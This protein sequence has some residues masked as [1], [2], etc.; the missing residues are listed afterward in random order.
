MTADHHRSGYIVGASL[1]ETSVK[2]GYVVPLLIVSIASHALA[3]A[4][5]K[6]PATKPTASATQS[7]ITPATEPDS[8]TIRIAGT[9]LRAAVQIMQQYLD[10][11]VIFTGQTGGRSDVRDAATGAARGRPEIAARAARVAGLRA[12][13]RLGIGHVSR[14]TKGTTEANPGCSSVT[15]VQQS[16][17]RRAKTA[18]GRAGTLRHC[19]QAR[20]R[21]GRR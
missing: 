11:P 17:A 3:Q 5:Q 9:E 15:R 14:A 19:A 2:T 1:R 10:R 8:V 4:S 18:G 21:R 16:R 6:P 7:P 13:R 12:R 20:A